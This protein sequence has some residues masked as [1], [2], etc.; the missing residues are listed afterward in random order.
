VAPRM[1][2]PRAPWAFAHRHLC[3][4]SRA[5]DP[6]FMP[7]ISCCFVNGFHLCPCARTHTQMS[8]RRLPGR[9]ERARLA[10]MLL[11]PRH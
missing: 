8:R 3:H 11:P 2:C 10:P 9:G 6:P 7:L 5:R 4:A 1:W